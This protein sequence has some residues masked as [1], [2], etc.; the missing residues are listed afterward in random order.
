[1]LPYQSPTNEPDAITRFVK[2]GIPHILWNPKVHHRVGESVNGPY[3][4]PN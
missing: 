2:Q 4:N 3:P 1:M